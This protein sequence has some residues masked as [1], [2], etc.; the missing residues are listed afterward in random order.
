MYVDLD[1]Q[2]GQ[3]LAYTVTAVDDQ[4]MQSPPSQ[5]VRVSIPQ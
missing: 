1:V 3:S 4:M 5:E 2:A